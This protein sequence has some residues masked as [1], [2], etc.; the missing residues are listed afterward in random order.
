MWLPS[1]QPPALAER[2]VRVGVDLVEVDR[3][4]RLVTEHVEALET[5]FTTQELGYCLPK[6]RRYEHLAARFAAK[7]AVLKAF[8]TGLSQGMCWKDVEVVNEAGGRPRVRLHGEV[9]RWAHRRRLVDLDVS[10]SHTAN[11]AIAQVVAVW[12][13]DHSGSGDRAEARNGAGERLDALLPR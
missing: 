11:L 10:L 13:K 7:E 8:G 5:L 3:L 1:V 4:A 12:G 2:T 6:R 9:A